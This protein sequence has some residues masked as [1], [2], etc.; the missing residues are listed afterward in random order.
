MIRLPGLIDTHVHLREPGATQKEDFETGTMAAIAGGYTTILDMPNNPEP[1]VSPHALQKKIYLARGASEDRPKPEGERRSRLRR[2]SERSDFEDQEVRSSELHRIYCD[3]GFHFGA[4][5]DSIAH[6]QKVAK[7]VFA[8]KVYMNHTTGTLLIEDQKLLERVF[9]SWPSNKVIMVHA[10]GKTLEKAIHLAAKFN[11]KLHVCHLS[12]KEQLEMVKKAKLSGLPVTCEVTAHH[13]FLT[14]KDVKHL[15]PFGLMRPPLA[16]K[17]DQNALWKDIDFIDTIASDHAP[18]TV[19]EKNQNPPPNGVPGLE[20][21]LPLLLN[22]VSG[23]RLS[24]GRL[25]DMTSVK[26]RHIFDIPAQ[27]DTYIEVDLKKPYTINNNLYT[28]CGWTPFKEMRVKGKVKRVILRGR[29][30]FENGKFKG[31]PSGQVIYPN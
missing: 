30:V 9:S 20:T 8:L 22:A 26:P 28:K 14:D 4:S 12:L 3:M 25:I 18:H 16:S 7:K 11:K 23:G 29:V 5:P 15:G 10:E 24:M 19:D 6:F 13:L 31:K 1:T 17:F 27:P 2:S 21:T